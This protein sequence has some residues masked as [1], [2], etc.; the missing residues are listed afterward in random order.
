PDTWI[1]TQLIQEG[2]GVIFKNFEASIDFIHK[3]ILGAWLV[4][5]LI[6]GHVTA[7]LYH[8][9]VRKDRTLKKMTF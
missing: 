6:V 5:M 7:A 9:F 3:N 8:H 4:W 2:L 1:F